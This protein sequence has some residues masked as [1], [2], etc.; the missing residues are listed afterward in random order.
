MESLGK[1]PIIWKPLPLDFI[2]TIDPPPPIPHPD[3]YQS[4]YTH[5]F[6]WSP[7]QLQ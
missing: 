7:P 5:P 6:L 4:N 3:I 2:K 1:S